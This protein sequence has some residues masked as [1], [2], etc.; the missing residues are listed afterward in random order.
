MIYAI[1]FV[2]LVASW[3]MTLAV[4]TYRTERRTGYLNNFYP[5]AI[6]A[7]LAFAILLALVS[8]HFA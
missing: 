6:L 4:S 8:V 1:L 3:L 2:A 7:V 5:R